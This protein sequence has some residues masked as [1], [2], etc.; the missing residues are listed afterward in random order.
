MHPAIRDMRELEEESLRVFTEDY[1]Y[2][3]PDGMWP[4]LSRVYTLIAGG[5]LGNRGDDR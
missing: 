5:V 1:G 2:R 4:R 3:I